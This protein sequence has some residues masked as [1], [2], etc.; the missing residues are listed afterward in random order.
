MRWVPFSEAKVGMLLGE[1]VMD[2]KGRFLAKK[3]ETLSP[4]MMVLFASAGVEEIL[5]EERVSELEN[6]SRIAETQ[7]QR[8]AQITQSVRKT[9]DTRFHAFKGNPVMQTVRDLA[10]KRLIQDKISRGSN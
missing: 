8:V 1:P 3:G 6:Q 2:C 9:L 4:E 7:R 5:A 10:E